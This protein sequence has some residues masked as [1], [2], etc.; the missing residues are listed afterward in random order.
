MVAN[1][2][3]GRSRGKS[4]GTWQIKT[5]IYFSGDVKKH[6]E[7]MKM[8]KD[9]YFGID[10]WKYIKARLLALHIMF[11]F[12]K[13]SV[14]NTFKQLVKLMFSRT[15]VCFTRVFKYFNVHMAVDFFLWCTKYI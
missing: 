1:S 13:T 4:V 6:M 7:D 3:A 12:I 14:K 15:L 10:W 2:I 11:E 9:P 8:N 5:K